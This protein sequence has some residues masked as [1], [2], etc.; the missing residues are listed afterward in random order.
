MSRKSPIVSYFLLKNC[1]KRDCVTFAEQLPV[2]KLP[3]ASCQ[4]AKLLYSC[5]VTVAQVAKSH[6]VSTL[7]QSYLLRIAN[8]NANIS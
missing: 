2:A 3:L 1:L 7:T 5:T 8:A 4:N 6:K